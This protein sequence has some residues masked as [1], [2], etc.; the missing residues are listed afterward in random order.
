MK[1]VIKTNVKD[2]TNVHVDISVM[3][4]YNKLISTKGPFLIFKRISHGG[5]LSDVVI[6]KASI[7]MVK[8]NL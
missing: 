7:K 8:T 2:N 6:P 5:A 1:T 3:E 4:V